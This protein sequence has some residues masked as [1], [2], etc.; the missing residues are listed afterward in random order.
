MPAL[1]YSIGEGGRKMPQEKIRNGMLAAAG[2]TPA[3]PPVG[4]VTTRWPRAFSSEPAS[5][6]AATMPTPRCFSY[7]S[8]IA[9]L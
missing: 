3:E 7:S 5:A 8:S 2:I 9:R 1:V 4:A 6:Y